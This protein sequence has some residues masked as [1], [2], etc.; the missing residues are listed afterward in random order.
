M[1]CGV[2]CWLWIVSSPVCVECVVLF[3]VHCLMCVA[4]CWLVLFVLCCLLSVVRAL[5]FRLS[6]VVDTCLLCVVCYVCVVLG[7]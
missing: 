7:G 1:L 5:F 4:C 3:V 2:Y 6:P